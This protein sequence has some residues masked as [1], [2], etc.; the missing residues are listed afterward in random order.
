MILKVSS[1]L[2]DPNL[3]TIFS[4]FNIQIHV[5]LDSSKTLILYVVY[6]TGPFTIPALFIP[7][8]DPLFHLQHCFPLLIR[9]MG[10]SSGTLPSSS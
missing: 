1:Y 2:G 10:H 8:S 5:L 7:L 9:T 6:N 4:N 3:I